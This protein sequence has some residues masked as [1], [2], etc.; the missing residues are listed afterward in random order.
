MEETGFLCGD[1]K[2]VPGA[3]VLASQPVVQASIHVLE[4]LNKEGLT[5]SI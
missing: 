5:L 4:L 2:T 1:E 3:L